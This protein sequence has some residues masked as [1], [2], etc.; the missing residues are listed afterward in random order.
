MSGSLTAADANITGGRINI[1]TGTNTFQFNT[2]DGIFLGS[3][4]V[5]TS[6]FHCTMSGVVTAED[7]T[8]NNYLKVNITTADVTF[9]NS[10]ISFIGADTAFIEYQEVVPSSTSDFR[11]I[12]PNGTFTLGGS[13]GV[14]IMDFSETVFTE[15][16]AG[17]IY[18]NSELVA[19]QQWVTDNF[20]P[21]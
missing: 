2:T 1:G 12:V 8:A 17:D 3:T 6:K 16:R 15:L 5:S 11:I 4:S 10:G 18:S 20:T 19:T 13:L 14:R 21:L 9:G 7:L